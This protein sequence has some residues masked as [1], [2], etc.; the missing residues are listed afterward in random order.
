MTVTA[1]N[2]FK[3]YR[4]SYLQQLVDFVRIP[5]IS[6]DPSYSKDVE[7]AAQWVANKLTSLGAQ[8]VEIVPTDRHPIVYAERVSKI[9]PQFTILIYGHYDVQPVD[10]I[11]LWLH[12]PFEPVIDNNLL[13]GR[14]AS[15][16]KGQIIACL[17][18]IE[19]VVKAG[20]L[21]I[22]YKFLVEG[23]EEIGSPNLKD[24]LHCECQKL[25]SDFA[26][27][28]DAGMISPDLPAITYGL[29]GIASFELQI[30]GPSRDLHSGQ[31][32]GAIHNPAQV[33][34]DL[35]SGM[36]DTNGHISV[37]GFYNDVLEI[38]INARNEINRLPLNEEQLLEQTGSPGI[39]GENE[40]TPAERI[41][42]R[43]TLEV[44]GIQSGYTGEGTKTIIPSSAMAKITT[45]LVPNQDP[46][47]IAQ[48]I[49]KY[50]ENSVPKSARWSLVCH[51]GSHAAIIDPELPAINLFANALQ[52]VWGVRPIFKREGGS[53][54]VV[55]EMKRVLGIDSVLSGFGLPEDNIHSPNERINLVC[56]DKGVQSIINFLYLLIEK[57]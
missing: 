11:G 29:R 13:Y 18:A 22:T 52:T 21:P 1:L 49:Y 30:Q 14:G 6:T 41:G 9:K 35:I 56:W 4:N 17:G 44:N 48:C 39:W 34:C 15:D 51:G 10:P 2:H 47:K 25:T 12:D 43:P 8:T 3:T 31:F 37:P 57:G 27:N 23:E 28:M 55:G 45:R 36:H 32:G 50:L 38:P 53:I 19:S 7:K 20:E 5:S 42:A 24:F 26:L 16:M 40:Y 54:P 46:D 33:I